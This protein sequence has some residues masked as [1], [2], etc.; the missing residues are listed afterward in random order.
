MRFA[1]PDI[2]S[3]GQRIGAVALMLAVLTAAVASSETLIPEELTLLDA[4]KATISRHPEIR[5]AEAGVRLN[6]G[7]VREARGRFDTTL[8][9]SATESREKRTTFGGDGSS[10][11]ERTTDAVE[12]DIGIGK[13]LRTGLGVELEAGVLRSETT[14][15]SGTGQVPPAN[16]AEIRFSIIQPLLKGRGAVAAAANERSARFEREAAVMQLRH[17]VSTRALESV[18]AYWEYVLRDRHVAIFLEAEERAKVLVAQLQK[19]IDRDELPATEKLQAVA[20]LAEATTSRMRG[21]QSLVAARQRLLLAMGSPADE[22]GAAISCADAFPSELTDIA[23]SAE[24]LSALPNTAVKIRHDYLALEA[25][26]KSLDI[27]RRAALRNS[28]QRLDLHASVGYNGFAEGD[29]M[30]DYADSYAGNVPGAS[31]VIALSGDWPFM[32]NS[33]L[34]RVMQ[35]TAAVE[36]ARLEK[37]NLARTIS[38]RIMVAWS[39]LRNAVRIL[40]QA[41]MSRAQYR[42]SL[43]SEKKKYLLDMASLLEV[44]TVENQVTASDLDFATARHRVAVALVQLRYEAGK[45]VGK[46]RESNVITMANL[47]GL[48]DLLEADANASIGRE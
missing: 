16:A 46:R 47:I 9:A 35:T 27:L 33:E 48:S 12:T 32:N 6:E 8:S 28:S 18:Q 15:R 17:V 42:K 41:G 13:E 38:S 21:E 29:T 3:R 43:R 26:E 34:G 37:E 2:L 7:R 4:V 30:G 31:F 25:R 14:T 39:D 20:N 19:L 1:G 5:M 36:Q 40:E 23:A 22:L 44:L 24:H 11:D 45:L 10:L